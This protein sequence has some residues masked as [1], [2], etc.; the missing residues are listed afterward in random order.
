MDRDILGVQRRQLIWFGSVIRMEKVPT[1]SAWV[2][3]VREE[4]ERKAEAGME[5]LHCRGD[6]DEGA[7][8]KLLSWLSPMETEG[9]ETTSAV[10]IRKK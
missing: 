8:R 9:G 3:T 1:K 4:A 2:G 5:G 7:Y 6:D 10:K